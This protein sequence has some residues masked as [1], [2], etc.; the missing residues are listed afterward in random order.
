M[1]VGLVTPANQLKESPVISG[2]PNGHIVFCHQDNRSSQPMEDTTSDMGEEIQG[3]MHETSDSCKSTERES[4]VISGVPD[5]HIVSCHQDT[6]SG[7]PME[8]T[9][10]DM[11]EESQRDMRET[12]VSCK[13]PERESPVISGV[14][15]GHIVSCHEDTGS[16]HPIEEITS[17]MGGEIPGDIRG[18]SDSCILPERANPGVSRVPDSLT[19]QP[20]EDID[21]DETAESTESE[22][23]GTSVSCKLPTC[24]FDTG[25]TSS[26][27]GSQAVSVSEPSNSQQVEDVT[28][29]MGIGASGCSQMSHL[30]RPD[31]NE[32]T[33]I[34]YRLHKLHS[35]CPEKQA[36][37]SK[38][39]SIIKT[40]QQEVHCT[41]EG[42]EEA[43][44]AT[45][46][47][48]LSYLKE[49]REERTDIHQKS[50]EGS[51]NRLKNSRREVSANLASYQQDLDILLNSIIDDLTK[52]L[53]FITNYMANPVPFAVVSELTVDGEM[54]FNALNTD[55]EKITKEN[56][57][58]AKAIAAHAQE[59]AS[60]I[61]FIEAENNL[62][63]IGM[64]HL[65]R[66]LENAYN[67]HQPHPDQFV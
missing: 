15:D 41:F 45:Y 33:V 21:D 59:I 52:K 47:S 11:G 24:T 8:D 9:N 35:I 49:K 28:G 14:P 2:I 66:Y 48:K 42:L 50:F 19:S 17:D 61:F 20:M 27:V 12:S 4:P 58:R 13:L 62:Q 37:L 39:L 16:G 40:Q 65:P 7:Q 26:K 46:E 63:E 6:G 30:R 1:Y 43:I 18:S 55:L 23:C 64:I 25:L 10:S 56:N 67:F 3:D 53:D 31:I 36:S 54:T 38:T 29:A 51:T 32:E 34:A 57:E 22:V 60:N 44:Q 5:G